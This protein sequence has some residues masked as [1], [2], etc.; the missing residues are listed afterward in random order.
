MHNINIY[1][2]YI[3]FLWRTG[4]EAEGEGEIFPRESISEDKRELSFLIL[5]FFVSL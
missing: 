1:S 4:R 5:H 2:R 3:S